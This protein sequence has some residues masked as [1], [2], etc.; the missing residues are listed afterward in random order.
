MVSDQVLI[1]RNTIHSSDERFSY[2]EAEDNLPDYWSTLFVTVELRCKLS[3]NTIL[4]VL[5]ALRHLKI[6]EDANVRDLV[7]EFAAGK[8]LTPI[9][10]EALYEHFTLKSSEAEKV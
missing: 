3:Q 6:W 2:H 1:Q 7:S 4:S 8:F 9:D 10:I 5:G